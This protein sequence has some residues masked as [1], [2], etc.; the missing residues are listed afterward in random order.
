[1]IDINKYILNI[2]ACDIKLCRILNCVKLN[3]SYT[4]KIFLYIDHISKL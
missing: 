2:F 4:M 3:I 1:M